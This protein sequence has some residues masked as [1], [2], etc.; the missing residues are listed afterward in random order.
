MNYP[1]PVWAARLL[2]ARKTRGWSQRDLARELVRT[3]DKPLPEVDSLIRRI[4]G[5]ETGEHRPDAFYTRLYCA[6]FDAT[7]DQLFGT[8]TTPVPALADRKSTRLN[9]SHVKIS[10]AVFCLK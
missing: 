8:T 3:S 9:S 1:A 6:V 5:H 4:R 7:E 10:Y 2:A